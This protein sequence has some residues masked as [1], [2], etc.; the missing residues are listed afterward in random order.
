MRKP[1]I[2]WEDPPESG[3]GRSVYMW[4]AA[5][6]AVRE[7]PG[8]WALVFAKDG[9]DNL[10]KYTSS[11]AQ[12]WKRCGFDAVSRRGNVYARWPVDKARG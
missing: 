4:G 10:R 7:C 12:N 11:L 5:M 8:R 2:K 9:R 3:R 1:E 6:A